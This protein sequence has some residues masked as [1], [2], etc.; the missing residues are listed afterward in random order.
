MLVLESDKG[1]VQAVAPIKAKIDALETKAAP[2]RKVVADKETALQKPQEALYA[3]WKVID[4]I[5]IRFIPFE[6]MAF[7]RQ[8]ELTA[9]RQAS[10]DL[11]NKLFRRR[12]QL[13][14]TKQFV[15]FGPAETSAIV[16]SRKHEQAIAKYQQATASVEQYSKL[17]NEKQQ[18]WQTVSKQH[19]LATQQLATAEAD[20]ENLPTA[21]KSLEAI[22]ENIADAMASLDSEIELA[23]LVI[24]FETKAEAYQSKLGAAEKTAREMKTR[25][26]KLEPAFELA[27]Q[28]FIAAE[29]EMQT[30]LKIK[31]QI[32][33]EMQLAKAEAEKTQD[34]AEAL[35]QELTEDWS[36]Q[37]AIA[38]LKP[39]MPEQFAWSVLQVTGVRQRTLDSARVELEKTNPLSKED[40]QNPAII[41]QREIEIEELTYQK[42]NGSVQAFVNVYSAGDGQNQYDFFATVD[43]A[44]FAANG[45]SI[46]SWVNPSSGNVTQRMLQTDDLA[47][48]ANDLYLT[49]LMRLPT[50][51]ETNAVVE[52]IQS[53]PEE[54][55]ACI[56]EIAWAL[57]NSA[58]FRF[59]H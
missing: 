36:S 29:V 18:S 48:G 59:N 58:E 11:W 13:E 54:K 22:R 52:Y 17:F 39:M 37:F 42:L 27:K 51:E 35:Q 19:S 1:L 26:K 16:A 5:R 4:E 28:V 41:A 25:L 21:V 30:R 24:L 55:Q 20:Q 14:T 40:K 32:S 7:A 10:L 33:Q 9:T 43:Q 53:R 34:V 57:L 44:L 15:A 6:E 49:Y 38:P 2:L 31:K 50:A 56:T 46:I 8:V 3:Q 45:D 12:A 23:Q 47:A